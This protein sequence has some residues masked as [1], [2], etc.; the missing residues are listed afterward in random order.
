[1]HNR[2]LDCV[3]HAYAA[4]ALMWLVSIELEG[5]PRTR[6]LA[7]LTGLTLGFISSFTATRTGRN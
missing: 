6:V 7:I 1:M 5:T 2:M 4:A 3:T